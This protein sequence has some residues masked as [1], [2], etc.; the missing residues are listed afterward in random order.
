[1]VR[2]KVFVYTLLQTF[3]EGHAERTTRHS[4]IEKGHQF[5][6]ELQRK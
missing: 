4:I 6:I 1:M 3:N 2:H 5:E